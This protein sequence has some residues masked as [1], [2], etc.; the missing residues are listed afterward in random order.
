MNKPR[1]QIVRGLPGSGKSTY[2]RKKWPHLLQ[3]EFDF[4]CMRGGEYAFGEMRN[5]EGQ[6]WLSDVISKSLSLGIDLVVAGVFAGKSEN[7]DKLVEEA[8]SK[9]YEIWIETMDGNYGN[10]HGVRKA[11]YAS[12]AADFVSD[13]ELYSRLN[14]CVHFGS[15]P[16]G[17]VIAPLSDGL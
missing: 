8:I 2:A 14:K 13:A 7:I 12:M 16:E 1:L 5:T 3:Y 15:M 11:D 4:Y 9:G 17:Y 6:L 10:K